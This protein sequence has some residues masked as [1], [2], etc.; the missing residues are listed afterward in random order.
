MKQINIKIN[1]RNKKRNFFNNFLFL[2]ASCFLLLAP[3]IVQAQGFVDTL[4][5]I[6]DTIINGISWI[7]YALAMFV[8]N[9]NIYILYWV[10]RV[11]LFNDF[12]NVEVVE[13]GWMVVNGFCNMFFILILLFVAFAVI[14]RLEGYSIKK[15]VPKVIIMA[16]LINFSKTICGL[17]IDAS[18]IIMLFFVGAFANGT[19]NFVDLLGIKQMWEYNNELQQAGGHLGLETIASFLAAFFATIVVLI[20]M[21]V[22]F[23]TLLMRVVM[24]WIYVILSP[25]AF[26]CAAFPAGASYSKKW[27]SE[28]TNN[29]I[30]GPV[31]GFFLWLALTTADKTSSSILEKQAMGDVEQVFTSS[32]PISFLNAEYFQTY[33]ITIGILVG[34]LMIAKG[35]GAGAGAAIGKGIGA[36]NTVGKSALGAAKWAGKR[37]A[38]IGAETGLGVAGYGLNKLSSAGTRVGIKTDL[39]V[40]KVGKF[41]S[42]YRQDLVKSRKAASAS[43]RLKYLEKIGIKSG[44]KSMTALGEVADSRVGR[45]TK[46]AGYAGASVAGSALTGV[47][48]PALIASFIAAQGARTIA[49]SEAAS[50]NKKKDEYK[51]FEN[52]SEG[53]KTKEIET[54][55]KKKDDDIK[56]INQNEWLSDSQKELGIKNREGDFNKAVKKANDDHEG[57]IKPKK[58]E[59]FKDKEEKKRKITEKK[60]IDLKS[61]TEKRE[62]LQK[63]IVERK[64]TAGRREEI[65]KEMGGLK[66][67]EDKIVASFQKAMAQIE[68]KSMFEKLG[69]KLNFHPINDY[70][71]NKVTMDAVKLGSK[72]N[73]NAQRR[74][75]SIAAGGR[76]MGKDGFENSTFYSAGG[77]TSAQV[78]F[79]DKLSSDSEESKNALKAMV[80][81]FGQ[82]AGKTVD[83]PVDKKRIESVKKGV[84]A[85]EKGGKDTVNLQVLV[86]ALDQIDT[87]DGDTKTIKNYKDSPKVIENS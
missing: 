5:G 30:V 38:R 68:D 21:L 31:L 12:I 76:V 6:S 53:Q 43:S 13:Q 65:N 80:D 2:F 74:V 32:I 7:I 58:E 47:G 48:M 8:S 70:H 87:G 49:S 34:G 60:D 17:I 27:W 9:V 4:F 28:F 84:A 19:N 15:M 10:G 81:E 16:I 24:L 62:N 36:V 18:Q 78:K 83:N 66:T 67:E 63:E 23:A 79:F 69:D 22:I 11:A 46:F 14:L 42:A 71:P 51:N 61:I 37:T 59:M 72:E 1:N 45:A 57:R 85:Y 77:Q 86:G 39:G 64:P 29:V 56:Q 25:I 35:V 52:A 55:R 82:F 50:K 20:V 33:I 73:D 44:S 26:L 54:A 75:N 40:G 41:S 3:N